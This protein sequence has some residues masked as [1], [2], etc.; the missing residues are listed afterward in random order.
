MRGATATLRHAA[1]GLE[2]ASRTVA[3]F[4]GLIVLGLFAA[5]AW[6]SLEA[7]DVMRWAHEVFGI[8]FLIALAALTVTALHAWRR[9]E[10]DGRPHPARLET[11]LQAA[12][13]IATL[14][15]TYTLLGIS[16]GIGSLAGHE[17]GPETIQAV[18][19]DLTRHFAMAFLTTVVGLPVSAALR[20]LIAIRARRIEA[21]ATTPALIAG[22]I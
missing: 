7:G 16:L 4:L 1:S 22:E 9:L 8:T 10:V 12:N 13:G 11:G 15:L 19:R 20:A 21:R 3:L 18:I 5:T 6:T 17:L 2:S 14:A